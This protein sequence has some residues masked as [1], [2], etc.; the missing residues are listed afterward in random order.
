MLFSDSIRIQR[1]GRE[2]KKSAK[3][4]D[5]GPSRK[6]YASSIDVARLAGVSQSAVSRTF[7]EGASVSAKTR[8]KVMKAADEL[9]YGPS[10]IPKIMLTHKSSLIAIV[11]GGLYNPFYA[12]VVE[13][14]SHAVQKSGSNV[15]LFSVNHG[16]YIDE[17]IPDILSYRV[18]GIVSALSI[19][20]AE[21]AERC[22]KMH[23][24]V[25]LFNNKLSNEWVASIC[26][27]NVE[28]GRQIAA[29]FLKRGARRFAYIGGKKGNLASEDRF[30]GYL[31]GLMQNGISDVAM[32]YGDFRHD[33]AFI[34][35]KKLLSS[36][37]PPDAIF[38]ANDLMAIG[39]M[40]AV[41]ALGLSVPDDV[42]V[43]GFDDIPAAAWPSFDLTTVRQDGDAMIGRA[44]DQ[45]AR[46]VDGE[47]LAGNSLHLIQA[48]L[49]ERGSTARE[50]RKAE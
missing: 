16:E 46:M 12:G 7:T 38:C 22:A 3:A 42:L 50:P 17:I 39:A 32:A 15:M 21:A 25:V 43:A 27:D 19:V 1:I 48:P 9:G 13:K 23:T 14:L 28:G 24:P 26:S 30:A 10:I 34:A 5:S 31:S 18:D 45:L 47:H 44:M 40:E 2:L 33:E 6:K 36:R 41:K 49:V 20:S 11:S 4:L 29:L 35:A 37:K 8:E